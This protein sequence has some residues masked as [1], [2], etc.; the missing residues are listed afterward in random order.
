MNEAIKLAIEKGGWKYQLTDIPV[1][2]EFSSRSQSGWSVYS[3]H[4]GVKLQKGLNVSEIILDPLFWQA[5]GKAL[6]WG[7]SNKCATCGDGIVSHGFMWD[8]QMEWHRFID[9]IADGKDVDLFFKD[10]IK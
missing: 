7:S 6:G 1:F 9:W 10:L 4:Q 5:L 8:W 2:E 3:E